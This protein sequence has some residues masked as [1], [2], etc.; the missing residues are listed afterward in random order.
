MIELVAERG[1]RGVTVRALSRVAG[2]STKSFYECFSNVEDCFVATY[3]RIVLGAIKGTAGVSQEPEARLRSRLA[4]FFA[5]LGQDRK[6][7]GL[8]LVDAPSSGRAT[9]GKIRAVDKAL[10]RCLLEWLA[11]A[12]GHPRLPQPLARGVTAAALHL[13]R[14]QLRP[15]FALSASAVADDFADWLLALGPGYSH[16]ESH[17][18]VAPP[19]TDPRG[20]VGS[21][22]T[23]DDRRFLMAAVTKLAIRDGYENLTVPSICRDAGVPRRTFDNCFDGVADCFLAAAESKV[24]A[25]VGRAEADAAGADN[26]ERALVRV[27]ARLCLELKRDPALA[28]LGLFDLLAPGIPGF[29]LRERLL[30][31]WARRLRRTAPKEKRPGQFA[32]EASVAAA[33]AIAAHGHRRNVAGGA[34]EIAFVLLAP[35]SGASVA[36]QAILAELRALKAESENI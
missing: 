12:S 22:R 23:V 16:R 1:Y 17:H 26:W 7:A 28:H 6:A 4:R 18:E 14:T 35:V 33:C 19:A 9:V 2:V 29:E 24:L 30:G 10:E 20:S 3:R 25:T 36:R 15:D 31:R 5:T 34:S 8:V 32:A 11:A 21:L 13:A 27:A